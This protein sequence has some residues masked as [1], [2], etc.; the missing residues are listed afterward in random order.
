MIFVVQ[1][2][3]NVSLADL[4][5]F[6]I[7]GNANKIVTFNSSD[8][9]NEFL[10][11][12]KKPF[13]ILGGGTNILFS[14][15]GFQGTIIKIKNNKINFEN[16][17]IKTDSGVLMNNFI[18]DCAKHGYNFSD[19]TWPGT[20]GGAI[21]GNAGT[22]TSISDHLISAKVCDLKTGE[23]NECSNEW[24]EFDYRSSKLKQNKNLII[25]SAV[26]KVSIKNN[27]QKIQEKIIAN[28]KKRHEKQPKGFSA[29]SFF[30][31]PTNQSAGQLIEEAGCKGLSVGDAE[32]SKKHANFIINNGKAT[33][34]DVIELA[35]EV[36]NRVYK[37]F[38]IILKPEV[39]II[40]EFGEIIPLMPT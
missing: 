7:G 1:I 3:K 11:I 37:K 24:L 22:K 27:P 20:I 34:K 10:K 13:F 32:V 9:I 6:R 33:Q 4:T 26:F 31:N 36:I 23:I 28:L 21:Y 25:I 39:Q 15:K 35:Q 12:N 14:N 17:L 5:S 18:S 8:N 19:F 38:N 40:N 30:K 2:K 29:G 16:G